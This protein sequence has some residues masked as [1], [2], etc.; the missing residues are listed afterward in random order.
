MKELRLLLELFRQ[1]LRQIEHNLTIIE[2][3]LKII[4]KV[5]SDGDTYRYFERVDGNARR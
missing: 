4:E 2:K 3:Q 5:L 1:Q